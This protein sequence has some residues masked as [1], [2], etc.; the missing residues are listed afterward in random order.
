MK[1]FKIFFYLDKKGIFLDSFE[2]IHLDSLIEYCVAIEE[3][4]P[5]I[6]RN[7]V[8]DLVELPLKKTE[9]KGNIFWNASVLFPFSQGFETLRFWR[10]KFRSDR[11][12]MTSG[13]PN[14]TMGVYREYNI[15]VPLMLIDGL[16]AYGCGD[17]EKIVSLLKKNVKFLG[18]KRAYGYGR[19]VGVKAEEIENDYSF[20]KDGLS[21]RFLPDSDGSRIIRTFPPYWNSHNAVNCS[22][23]GEPY[24]I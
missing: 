15:P 14:L 24:I 17:I 13:S 9:I 16:F 6:D 12:E 2:P 1:N 10:K 19:I 5:E 8:P 7:D 20:V 11:I 4:I 21:M 18:K 22:E 3:N 23:I